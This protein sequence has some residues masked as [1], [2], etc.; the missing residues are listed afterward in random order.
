MRFILSGLLI[1]FISGSAAAQSGTDLYELGRRLKQFEAAWEDVTDGKARKRGVEALIPVQA[2]FQTFQ[3]GEAGRTLDLATHALRSDSPPGVSAQWAASLCAAPEGRIVDATAKELTV[4][5]RP[6]YPVK[7]DFPKGLE[8]QLWFSDKQI[9]VVKPEKFPHVVKVPMPDVGESNGLDRKLYFMVESGKVI[10]RQPIGV[11]QVTDAAG[12]IAALKKHVAALPAVETIEHATLKDRASLLGSLLNG[13]VWDTDLPAAGLLANAE[14]I[15]ARKPVFAADKP[16]EFW[17]SVPD[18]K[19]TAALRVFIPRGLDPAKP[20]PVVV[21]L[22]GLGGSENLFFEGYGAGFAVKEC[23]KRGWA[24]VA[25]RSGVNFSSGPP[26]AAIVD[27]L[28]KRYPLDVKRVFVVGHSMG[29][30]QVIANAQKTPGRFAAVAALG[31]GGLVTDAK[32]FTGLPVFLAAGE[33]DF[34]LAPSR[35]LKKSLTDGGVK[36]VVFQE[37]PGIEHLLIVRESLPDVFDT[38]DKAK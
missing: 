20:V 24:F 6:F 5:V 13:T 35:A 36:G 33:K 31:G 17:M 23:E 11:S 12:R 2:Q 38:F 7:G 1:A 26:V 18:G 8:V 28:A 29:A 37:Y 25:P 34:G 3:F 14:A 15:V 4:T 16:G 22:H 19:H 27:T 30:V 21:G 10:R 9:A 32:A